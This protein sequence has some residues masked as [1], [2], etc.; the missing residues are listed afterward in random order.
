MEKPVHAKNQLICVL[1]I[2]Q[3]NFCIPIAIMHLPSSV[4]PNQWPSISGGGLQGTYNFFQIQFHWGSDSLLGGSEHTLNNKRYA[5]EMQMMHINSKYSSFDEAI[6][7]GDGL[8][9]LSILIENED[10]GN[11]AFRHFTDL[12]SRIS[13]QGPEA[14]LPY[15]IPLMDLLPDNVENFYRYKGSLTRPGCQVLVYW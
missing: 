8:A 9:I 2:F 1:M 14:S 5:A 12:L 10:R 11:I 13:Y 4:T 15:T 3:N 7:Q 6:L